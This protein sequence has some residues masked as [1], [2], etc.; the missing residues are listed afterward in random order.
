MRIAIVAPSPV[1]FVIGGAEKLFWGLVRNLNRYTPHIVELIKVPCQDDRFWGLMEGYRHFANLDLS[2]YDVVIS[3]KYPAWMISHPQHHVY[4]QH[5]C[6]GVYDLY[7]GSTDDII[8]HV[9]LVPLVKLMRRFPPSREL[10]PEFFDILFS[11]RSNDSIPPGVLHLPSPFSRMIIRWLDSIAL[12]PASVRS[13]SAIS[14]T[15]ADREG[16]FPPGVEVKVLHHP[17]DLENFQNEDYQY[18]FTASRLSALKRIDLLIKAFRRIDVD[19]PFFIA[20]TGAEENLLKSLAAG[21][22]RI[23]FLG[24]VNDDDLIRWYSNALFVPF[25]PYNEDYGLITVEAMH[26]GKAVLTTHDSGGVNELVIHGETGLSVE[27]SEDAIAEAMLRMVSDREKTIEM[28]LKAKEKVAHITWEKFVSSLMEHITGHMGS[29]RKIWRP[30]WNASRK[31]LVVN[32]FPV[33]PPVSGGRIRLF[34]IAKALSRRASVTLLTLAPYNS[35]PAVR[36]ITP[37]FREISVPRSKPHA[38]E[39][40]RWSRALGVSAEDVSAINAWA[41][42]PEYV[43][44]LKEHA[45]SSDLVVI[46][47]PYLIRAV[48]KYY[49]GE[50]WYDAQDVE[51]DLKAWMYPP[52]EC[53]EGALNLIREAESMCI[54][55]SSLIFSC[56]REDAVRL[57][58]L[59]EADERRLLVVPNGISC[60]EVFLLAP[61]ERQALR[62][63][64]EID[65]RPVAIFMGS[66]HGPNNDAAL[67]ISEL[68]RDFPQALFIIIGSTCSALK[69]EAVPTNVLPLGVVSLEAKAILLNAA[70]VALNPVEGGSGTNLKML[71][72]AAYEL[73]I[74]TTQSG[75]RGLA[76]RDGKEVIVSPR[77]Q[78][79][80]ILEELFGNLLQDPNNILDMARSAR[81][82]ALS[83]YEWSVVTR[84]LLDLLSS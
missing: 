82:M 10:L 20:G 63:R 1:P 2:S 23:H 73:P 57:Q 43:D 14:R 8:P 67:W 25:I 62:S 5:P 30:G 53:R 46:S 51:V 17:S 81:R 32:T 41:L 26:S 48:R 13:Y 78:W 15:V 49:N 45:G 44:L 83:H 64:L 37:D 74:I 39:D 40:A 29:D 19:I 21:D 54:T 11:L 65:S 31:V 36:E 38:E 3:T 22:D 69:S 71:E 47:H 27:P 34:Q 59:Y 24:F 55:E 12:H 66:Y 33:Y 9:D 56:S 77:S 35:P 70:N 58:E 61:E 72:Y 68:A 42:T 84:P 76:F 79:R 60:D 6:R 4:M 16:Y 75:N 18:L 52:S 7:K 28:G 50:I 80:N